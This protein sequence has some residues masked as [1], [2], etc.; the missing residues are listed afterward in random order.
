[1]TPERQDRILDVMDRDVWM[2]AREIR[3][4][5][6]MDTA[7]CAWTLAGLVDLGIVEA[8]T[9]WRGMRRTPTRV[10]RLAVRGRR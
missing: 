3:A 1:M 9:E 10:Y 4:A 7:A 8:T 5:S 6:R 2:S